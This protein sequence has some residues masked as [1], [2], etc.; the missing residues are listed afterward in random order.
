MH[1]Y[2]QENLWFGLDALRSRGENTQNFQISYLCKLVLKPYKGSYF[3]GGGVRSQ[4]SLKT[5]IMGTV[6]IKINFTEK[7]AKEK[8][9]ILIYII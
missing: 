4:R 1:N 8:F 6:L 3:R 5:N 7:T 9:N 2:D